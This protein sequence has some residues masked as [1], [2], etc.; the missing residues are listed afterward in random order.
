S[1][2]WRGS[3]RP[4]HRHDRAMAV[5]LESPARLRSK[6]VLHSGG[7]RARLSSFD[8]PHFVFTG[9]GGSRRGECPRLTICSMSADPVSANRERT[10]PPRLA[11]G[12]ELRDLVFV[13]QCEPDVIEPFE[14]PPSSVIVHFDGGLE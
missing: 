9:R 6:R 14:E 12:L 4:S 5:R 8:E 7:Q 11:A 1:P 3:S 13:A 10:W 2:W